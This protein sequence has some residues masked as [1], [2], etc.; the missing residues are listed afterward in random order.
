MAPADAIDPDEFAAWAAVCDE[1]APGPWHAFDDDEEGEVFY[2][3]DDDGGPVAEHVAAE[4]ADFIIL[5]R[6]AMPRL[7]ARV[8][9][10]EAALAGGA[11]AHVYL[12][13][14]DHARSEL[15]VRLDGELSPDMRERLARILRESGADAWPRLWFE[16]ADR[17]PID[18]DDVHEAH[19]AGR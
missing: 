18:P 8:R 5:A 4:D 14:A 19:H 2:I 12:R 6:E 16:V 1:A 10:L 7:V 3:E 11:G 9:E 15:A 13:A 17:N